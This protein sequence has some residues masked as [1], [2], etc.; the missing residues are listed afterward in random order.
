MRIPFIGLMVMLASFSMLTAQK[1]FYGTV[2]YSYEVKG[3]NA[4]M[5]ATMMPQKMIIKYGEKQMLTYM[6]G[7]MMGSMMGKIIA[8]TESGETFIVKDD[9]KAVYLMK[10]EDQEN[11][12]AQE[13]KKVVEEKET[14]EILGHTCKKYTLTVSQNGQ[15]MTQTL[16]VTEDLKAPNFKMPGAQQMSGV[17]FSEQI[18]G[19]PMQ[20]EVGLPGMNTSMVMTVTD[21]D[22]S[23][24]S[25]K[26]F[27]RPEG[28]QT[29]DFSEFM[30]GKF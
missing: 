6:E 16:W 7:G 29:K 27:M 8:D 10:K 15:E 23:K 28:Y 13:V 14:K 5:M 9:E 30:K 26:E 18:K 17:M 12:E 11:A 22:Q 25:K 20:V 19:F 3:E 1:T 4:G 2:T 21:L 24:V